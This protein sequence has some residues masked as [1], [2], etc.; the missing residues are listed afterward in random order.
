MTRTST[1]PLRASGERGEAFAVPLPDV[2]PRQRC[3]I[4]V[5]VQ[6]TGTVSGIARPVVF[7]RQA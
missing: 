1:S 7:E 5:I 3:T 6:G 2:A 4:A